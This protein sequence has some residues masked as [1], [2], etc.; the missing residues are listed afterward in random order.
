MAETTDAPAQSEMSTAEAA[1]VAARDV[2]RREAALQEIRHLMTDA[3]LDW[4]IWPNGH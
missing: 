4:A 3:R 1:A 2:L